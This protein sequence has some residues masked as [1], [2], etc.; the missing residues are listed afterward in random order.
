MPSPASRL[1]PR[2]PLTIKRIKSSFWPGASLEGVR[3]WGWMKHPAVDPWAGGAHSTSGDDGHE[4]SN[5]LERTPFGIF[6]R[7]NIIWGAIGGCIATWIAMYVVVCFSSCLDVAAI[8]LE[9]GKMLDIDHEIKVVGLSNVV[10]GL[11]GGM[12]SSSYLVCATQWAMRGGVNSKWCS[13]TV[14]GCF[15]LTYL[16]PVPLIQQ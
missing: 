2:R 9:L 5:W 4:N 12:G 7:G 1:R 8:Q 14:V 11:S 13:A 16:T 3:N 6:V 10:S 15:A